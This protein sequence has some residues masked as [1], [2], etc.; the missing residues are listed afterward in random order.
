MSDLGNLHI[1]VLRALRDGDPLV[2][3]LTARGAQVHELTVQKI[4]PL[5]DEV[6]KINWQIEHINTFAKAIFVSSHATRF[7]LEKLRHRYKTTKIDARCFAIGPTSAR[8]RSKPIP[9]VSI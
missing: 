7:A 5:G 4:Y 2:A 8:S 6:L 9:N 3:N 1:I